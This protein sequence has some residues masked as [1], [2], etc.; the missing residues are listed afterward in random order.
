MK[1]GSKSKKNAPGGWN[2]KKIV[3]VVFCIAFAALMVVS[4]LGFGWLES[5]KEVK[6][7]DTIMLSYTVRDAQGSPVITTN[8]ML[9]N[10]TIEKGNVAFLAAPLKVVTN[11]TT[12]KEIFPLE[13]FMRTIAGYQ[14]L[15]YALFGPEY[16]SITGGIAGLRQGETKQISLQGEENFSQMMTVEEFEQIGGNY[17]QAVVGKQM[18]I[19]F[20]MDPEAE[21]G[22]TTSPQSTVSRVARINAKTDGGIILD[23]GL[24]VVEVTVVEVNPR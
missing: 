5:L 2:W 19:G 8:Q 10:Q 18:L 3:I 21:A 1:P 4:S 7:G 16:N 13:V 17:S 15:F 22:N 11:A 20:S 23:Y 12:I 24:D 6:A 14:P 9:Y